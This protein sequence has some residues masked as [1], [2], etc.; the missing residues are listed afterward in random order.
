MRDDQASEASDAAIGEVALRDA[1][2]ATHE[3]RRLRQ[4]AETDLESIKRG[5]LVMGGREVLDQ[6]LESAD[7][8][9]KVLSSTEHDA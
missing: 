7:Q 4:A 2:Q 8:F 1:W 9:S 3:E 5:I 6:I